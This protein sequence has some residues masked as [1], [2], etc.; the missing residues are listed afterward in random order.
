[1]ESGFEP[2]PP[3]EGGRRAAKRRRPDDAAAS[4]DGGAAAASSAAAVARAQ[5]LEDATVAALMDA[6]YAPSF[7]GESFEYLDH[8]ADVQIHSCACPNAAGR[9]GG[10]P[11]AARGAGG[12]GGA[13][14]CAGPC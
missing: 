2:L 13:P 7:T 3:R 6:A 12:G 5:Q 11:H 8:T 9:G 1:M 14:P 4:A 10:I